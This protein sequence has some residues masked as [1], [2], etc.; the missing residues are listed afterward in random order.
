MK[1]DKMFEKLG[2]ESLKSDDYS[3]IYYDKHN[4]EIEFLLG[5]KEVGKFNTLIQSGQGNHFNLKEL[6][7]VKEKIKELKWKWI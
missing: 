7:A 6:E 5:I 4:N 1:A 3:I 2:Y